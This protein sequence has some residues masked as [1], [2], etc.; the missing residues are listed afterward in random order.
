MVGAASSCQR[1]A[2]HEYGIGAAP[3]RRTRSR[4]DV[5]AHRADARRARRDAEA[6]TA[7][8]PGTRCRPA[9]G[10]EVRA[11]R[12]PRCATTRTSRV[13]V[14][15]GEGKSFSAGGDLGML[16]RRRRP[17]RNATQARYGRTRRA[18]FTNAFCRC[19]TLPIPTLAAINGPRHW[20]RAVLRAGL[21]SAHRGVGCEDGNDLHSSLGI[22]PGMGATYLL[23][24][25][26]GAAR[27][28][29]PPLHRPRH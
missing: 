2:A 24:R 5:R 21:R 6:S 12:R 27:A 23:P 22:H 28:C 3:M 18:S 19:A 7:R 26:V 14:V 4:H 8:T 10:E 9:M 16:A 29:R 11:R 25:L 13:L 1:P 17:R 20:R 15:T